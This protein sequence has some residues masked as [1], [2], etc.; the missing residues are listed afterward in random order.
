M[1]ERGG[2]LRGEAAGA[3]GGEAGAESRPAVRCGAPR[4]APRGE[5]GLRT[6]TAARRSPGKPLRQH[7]RERGAGTMRPPRPLWPSRPAAWREREGSSGRVGCG[8]RCAVL[9][10][11]RTGREAALGRGAGTVRAGRRLAG[12]APCG[13]AGRV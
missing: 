5:P 11:E 4:A 7:G 12:A 13:P 1:R 2:A 9:G 6:E 3:G 10:W 8:H